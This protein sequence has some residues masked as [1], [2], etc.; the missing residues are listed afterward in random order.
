MSVAIGIAKIKEDEFVFRNEEIKKLDEKKL[1]IGYNVAFDWDIAKEF[2][3][4]KMSIHYTYRIDSADI[5]LVRFSSTTGFHVK[6][7]KKVLVV[8]GAKFKLPEFFMMTFLSTA[9]ASSRGMLAY[10]L[11]GTFL[12][13]YYLPLVDP[14][15]FLTHFEHHVSSKKE[16]VKKKVAAKKTK[17]S[18]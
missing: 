4:V 11:S 7:L 18:I 12:S 2:F 3:F 13:E 17:K 1:T 6:G 10:K 8:D 14:K 15:D 5:E 9:V 16:N